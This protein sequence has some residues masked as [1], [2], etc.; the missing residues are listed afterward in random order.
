GTGGPRRVTIERETSPP[1]P[2]GLVVPLKSLEK[3]AHIEHG[4]S[5]CGIGTKRARQALDRLVDAA[6]IVEDIG[7]V[8][9][10]RCE[11]RTGPDGC[12]IGGL[13]FEAAPARTQ[14]IS[15]VKRR[16]RVRG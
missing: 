9:P 8:V 16:G 13:R 10:C 7:E 4:V 1:P 15:E 11:I 5:V 6:L 2:C 12:A 14:H 3:K